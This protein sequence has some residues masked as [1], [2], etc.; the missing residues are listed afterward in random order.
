MLQSCL[1][2]Y[3]PMDC[4]PPVS[5]VHGILQA[6]ILEWTAIPFSR[7]S[8]WPRDWTWVSCIAG[9]FFTIWAIGESPLVTKL[10]PTFCDLMA[11]RLL[12]PRDFPSK[13]TKVGSHFLL[14][15]IFPEPEIETASPALQMDSLTLSHPGDP[16]DN[17]SRVTSCKVL[18]NR[19]FGS[20]PRKRNAK[21][22]N[23][24]L[25]RPYN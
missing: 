7:G 21:K 19:W 5:S 4:S 9:R 23:G 1:T 6:R 18:Y 13:N 14:Q 20:G 24:C 12:C 22:Q 10:Y 2:L 15:G 17:I 11:C 3:D 16:K 25:R 8:S